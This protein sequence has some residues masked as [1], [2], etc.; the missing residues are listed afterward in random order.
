[1]RNFSFQLRVWEFTKFRSFEFLAATEEMGLTKVPGPDSFTSALIWALKSLVKEK[2]NGRFTTVELRNKIK[3]DAPDFPKD[4]NPV[5]VPRLKQTSTVRIML[6]PL[7]RQGLNEQ[8]SV[9]Q[10]SLKKAA[11]VDPFK[12][13]TLTL[14]FDFG[15]KP[16]QI[17]IGII[18]RK[19]NGVFRHTDIGLSQ[20]RWGG[21][22]QS[23]VARAAKSFQDTL[24]KHRRAHLKL[25]EVIPPSTFPD[26]QL[27]RNARDP[28]TPYSSDQH[29][30]GSAE[31]AAK[32]S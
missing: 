13:H 7:Q 15:D 27:S 29:S 6:H 9:K 14:H 17:H 2:E 25:P 1:M 4:Q 26:T 30:R 16:S 24:K 20:I 28:L 12:R 23:M 10:L 5:L 8:G 21:R 31:P 22:R 18:G 3:A 11:S 19:L 32:G